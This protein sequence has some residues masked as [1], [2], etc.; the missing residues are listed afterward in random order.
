MMLAR[1]SLLTFLL[2]LPGRTANTA[3]S[4]PGPDWPKL[5]AGEILTSTVENSEGIPGIRLEMVV[6]AGRK[7]VWSGLVDYT[8]YKNVFKD[9]DD[10]KVI[11]EDEHGAVVHYWISPLGQDRDY[12]L[13]RKYDK[14][15]YR[16]SWQRVSGDFQHI[17]GSWDIVDTSDRTRLLLIYHSY[18]STGS[19]GQARLL[20]RF[21][22]SRAKSSAEQLRKQIEAKEAAGHK[23]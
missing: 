17:S 3:K 8:A 11:K 9:V 23:P 6:K 19:W 10:L 7:A 20:R 16:L 4:P 12:V 18:V 1:L 15:L 2:F 14:P 13:D 5:M 21:F 22:K